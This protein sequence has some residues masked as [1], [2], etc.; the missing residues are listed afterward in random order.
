MPTPQSPQASPNA[1]LPIVLDATQLSCFRSCPQKFYLEFVLGLRPPGLSVDLHAGSCFASAIEETYRQIYLNKKSLGEALL[2]SH[3][4]FLLEWGNF[5]IPPY[6]H[7][8]KTLDRMWEAVVGDGTPEGIGYFQEY[9]PLSDHI[10]PYIASDGHP[11]LEYTFAIPLEPCTDEKAWEMLKKDPN[12]PLKMFP[13]HP[14]GQPFL[15]CGRF[16]MLGEKDGRPL[17]VD[18]KTTAASPSQDWARK[19]QLRS[20]FIGYVW[21]L[22]QCNLDVDSV[23]VR[24][25]SIMREKIRHM[26]HIQTY[27]QVVID[28]WYE[29]LRRDVWRIRQAWDEQY[30]DFNLAESCTSYGNCV[31]MDGCTARDPEEWLGEMQVRRWDP[32]KKNPVASPNPALESAA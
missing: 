28:R 31:F 5:E 15:Y 7:T 11:T 25:I 29:Q 2:L 32:L 27:S 4:K 21:A 13:S 30:F 14:S 6:K 23:C 16:D 9:P 20:Q 26:E 1:Q 19:W 12:T 17:P 18:Q 3:A 8:A 10:K 22:Q 24:G